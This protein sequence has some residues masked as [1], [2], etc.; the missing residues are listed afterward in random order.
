MVEEKEGT[1]SRV[2]QLYLFSDILLIAKKMNVVDSSSTPSA[3]NPNNFTLKSY[4]TLHMDVITQAT[5]VSNTT[6]PKKKAKD[7]IVDVLTKTT[8]TNR[9]QHRFTEI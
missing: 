2:V 5:A 3:G 9:K 1:S 4:K 7:S 8:G 6:Q